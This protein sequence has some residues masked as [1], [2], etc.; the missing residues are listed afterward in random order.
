MQ[1][2]VNADVIVKVAETAAEQARLRLEERLLRAVAHPGVAAVVASRPEDGP[3]GSLTLAR[4]DGPA[5]AE[6]AG[7]PA[8]VVAGWGA[9]LATTVA[10]LH[11]LGCF[12]G[13]LDADHVA[14]DRSGKPVLGGFE[15]AVAAADPDDQRRLA[16]ADT[17][18]L[19]AL[20]AGRLP[21]G[22][23]RRLRRTLDRARTAGRRPPTARAL[24]AALV[25]LVPGARLE[26]LDPGPGSAP[27]EA[28]AVDPDPAGPK[29]VLPVG[30]VLRGPAVR[31]GRSPD[32]RVTIGA[33]AALFLVIAGWLGAGALTAGGPDRTVRRP[34]AG[35]TPAADPT[36]EP[37]LAG[38]GGRFR[39][40][41]AAGVA[42]VVVTGR[43]GCGAA[44]P[45]VLDRRSGYLW[46]LPYWPAPGA[47]VAARLVATVGGATGLVARPG[48][49]GCDV[50]EATRPDGTGSVVAVGADR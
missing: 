10:D 50:L 4:P 41:T 36:A 34:A 29:R 42:P 38:P 15:A 23:D 6:V 18:A 12:H 1:V 46:V 13:A 17:A 25:D 45:A 26:P 9:A 27:P 7:Q 44:R 16:R 8:E 2:R 49:T 24:A 11:D 47:H 21:G 19:A 30:S 43:W 14:F 31:G 32:H 28:V 39:L 33:A 37:A 22:V 35:R 3:F 48:G 40:E 20:I 5:L